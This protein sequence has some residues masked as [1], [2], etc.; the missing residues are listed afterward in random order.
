MIDASGKNDESTL[1]QS[2]VAAM[3]VGVLVFGKEMRIEALNRAAADLLGLPETKLRGMP[4]DRAFGE[5]YPEVEWLLPAVLRT[6][7]TRRTFFSLQPPQGRARYLR[8]SASL[9]PGDELRLLLQLEDITEY[10]QGLAKTVQHEKMAAVG[11]LAAGIAH[12]FNNIWASIRGFAELARE[13]AEHVPELLEVILSQSDRAEEII[14]SLLSFS[15]GR[16][17]L[18]RGVRLKPIIEG[19]ARI[20]RLELQARGIELSVA[21]HDDP[22]LVGN[23][24]MLQQIFLNL[25]INAY[26]A[27]EGQGRIAISLAREGDSAVVRVRDTGHGMTSEQTARLFEP[28]F[29][30]KGALGGNVK[31]AGHG[32][33]LTMTYNLVQAHDGEI[34]V[35][36]EVDQGSV[37]TVRLP[38]A[39]VAPYAR[40][41]PSALAATGVVEKGMHLL[42][43]DD[44]T[45]FHSLVR[46][47]FRDMHV[48]AVSSG[49]EALEL[50]ARTEY[51]VVLLDIILKGPVGGLQIFDY[52]EKNTPD[53]RVVFISG[54]PLDEKIRPAVERAAG[55][56]R[57]PFSIAEIREAVIQA[58]ST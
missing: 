47:I 12:E 50:L 15:E 49:E 51:D 16:V 43:V 54:R 2:V 14:R 10:N 21:I 27:I 36:S 44:E 31:V 17:S 26:Q 19:V 33:G 23:P 29:T 58:V 35:E 30:T 34:T 3:D 52:I 22:Q 56:V 40:E 24:G 48:R 55:L 53:T 37:F 7:R 32:L 57:K 25:V 4:L 41:V 11:L 8:A 1:D 13:N 5:S 9:L 42:F 6:S 28:F 39:T 18:E 38:V 46:G 45:I 20:V